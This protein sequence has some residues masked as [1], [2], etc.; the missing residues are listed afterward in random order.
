MGH[1]GL[2]GRP[3]LGVT[4]AVVSNLLLLGVFAYA[5]IIEPTSSDFYYRSVQEDEYIEWASF[6]AF[7]VAG[8]LFI[9]GTLGQRRSFGPNRRRD[10]TPWEI[11]GDDN[12]AYI[13]RLP[14][15][16]RP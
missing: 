2:S 11:G 9:L 13:F 5:A 3:R 7:V 1:S 10:S 12:G 16:T 8:G 6:W 4:T 15:P 14:K